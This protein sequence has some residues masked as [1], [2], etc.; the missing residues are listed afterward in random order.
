MYKI[1]ES[2]ENKTDNKKESLENQGFQKVVILW[3]FGDGHKISKSTQTNVKSNQKRMIDMNMISYKQKQSHQKCKTC[4]LDC[5]AFPGMPP[6]G[7]ACIRVIP[8][9]AVRLGLPHRYCEPES[10][11]VRSVQRSFRRDAPGSDIV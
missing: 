10:D 5:T 7:G 11:A 3:G 2:S 4:R 9:D 6:L 1:H 8:A